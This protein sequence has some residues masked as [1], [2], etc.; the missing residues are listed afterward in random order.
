M[1]SAGYYGL[2]G[3]IFGLIHSLSRDIKIDIPSTFDTWKLFI[4]CNGLIPLLISVISIAVSGCYIY[5]LKYLK[6]FIIFMTISAVNALFLALES[7]SNIIKH[8]VMNPLPS[9]SP[10]IYLL[11]IGISLIILYTN[12]QRLN[13]TNRHAN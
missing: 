3:S 9:Y 6:P 8:G 13:Q 1:K 7:I 12:Q 11:M 4:E 5:S 10:K 2:I